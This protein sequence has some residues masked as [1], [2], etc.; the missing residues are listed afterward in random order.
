M[1]PGQIAALNRAMDEAGVTYTTEVYE[2]ARH[3]YTMSDTP[4]YDAAAAQRH[5]ENLF[6]LL[7]RTLPA[8]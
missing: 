2:G 3:G 5:Y 7:D 1:D 6:A 4:V 8:G